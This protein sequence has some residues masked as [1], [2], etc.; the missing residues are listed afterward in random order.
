MLDQVFLLQWFT[1]FVLLL[2]MDLGWFRISFKRIYEP[3][4]RQI[5]KRV[6]IRIWS[7][8]FVWLLLGFLVSGL[9]KA[10]KGD[11]MISGYIGLGLGFIVYAVYNFTNYATLIHYK[12][13][14]AIVDSIWGS[15]AIGLTSFFI[16]NLFQQNYRRK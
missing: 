3:Q 9:V 12:L 5:Q 4:F 16:A 10:A 2:L 6:A 15:L 13:Q 14:V 11:T 7:A 1:A 8:I